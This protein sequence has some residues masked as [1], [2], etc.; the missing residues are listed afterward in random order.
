[1]GPPSPWE[2]QVLSKTPRLLRMRNTS[3]SPSVT[4]LIHICFHSITS[5]NGSRCSTFRPGP[6]R[7]WS[8]NPPADNIPINFDA[9][10]D[11]PRQ[12]EWRADPPAT[13]FW[14]EDGDGGIPKR[15][16]PFGTPCTRL[17][18]RSR[19]RRGSSPIC[20][21]ALVASLGGTSTWHWWKSFAGRI[22]SARFSQLTRLARGSRRLYLTVHSRIDITTQG[23]RCSR[24]TRPAKMCSSPLQTASISPAT[25]HLRTATGPS[26]LL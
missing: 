22:G 11:G 21:C 13:L 24:R 26:W 12:Y 7:C 25:E 19:G 8:T 18:L 6:L 23:A 2:I 14:V 5:R 4:I 10:V 17:S 1:M 3:S 16:F 15:R 9:V 20:R